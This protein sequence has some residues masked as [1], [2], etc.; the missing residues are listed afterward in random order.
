MGT[1]D[2]GWTRRAL[3]WGGMDHGDKAAALQLGLRRHPEGPNKHPF[4]LKEGL[5]CAEIG[6]AGP[7]EIELVSKG[8]IVQR[9]TLEEASHRECTPERYVC[10]FPPRRQRRSG[11]GCSLR[12]ACCEVGA[13]RSLG[14]FHHLSWPQSS[15][16][17]S[18]GCRMAYPCLPSQRPHSPGSVLVEAMDTDGGSRRKAP[19]SSTLSYARR[20]TRYA[21][22]AHLPH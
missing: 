11:Y 3:L 20:G 18:G 2:K 21:T 1:L 22:L 14:R 8:L 4:P 12:R 5:V 15:R 16:K 6:E 13:G 7:Y 17:N 9:H 10:I 19:A